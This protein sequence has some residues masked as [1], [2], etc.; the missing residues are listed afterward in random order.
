MKYNVPHYHNLWSGLQYVHSWPQYINPCWHFIK[1]LNAI[2]PQWPCRIET[3][4]Y[5]LIM[6]IEKQDFAINL[7]HIVRGAVK[8][9]GGLGRF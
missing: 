4:G 3:P 1:K 2:S 9:G 7:I 5:S 8:K 6:V